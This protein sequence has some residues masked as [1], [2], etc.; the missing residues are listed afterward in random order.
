MKTGLQLT[1]SAFGLMDL[2]LTEMGKAGEIV[3]FGLVGNRGLI[4]ESLDLRNGVQGC[5]LDI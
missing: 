2:P 1:T 3:R 5:S 4:L